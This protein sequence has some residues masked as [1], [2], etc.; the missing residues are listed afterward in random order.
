M[1]QFLAG[2]ISRRWMTLLCITTAMGSVALAQEFPLATRDTWE[3][4]GWSYGIE[5]R[6]VNERSVAE[7]FAEEFVAALVNKDKEEFWSLIDSSLMEE[8]SLKLCETSN[9]RLNIRNSVRQS[10][11]GFSIQIAKQGDD[12]TFVRLLRT[13]LGVGPIF[14]LKLSNGGVTYHHWYL[15]QNN[16]GR[17]KGV[18]VYIFNAGES[19]AESMRRGALLVS[20]S[21]SKPFVNLLSKRDKDLL[22]HRDAL[23]RVIAAHKL[24]DEVQIMQAYNALP[25]ELK[26]IKFCM[27]HKLSASAK[28]SS[29]RFAETLAEFNKVYA[30]DV[31][32]DLIAMDY[33]EGKG[34]VDNLIKTVSRIQRVIHPDAHLFMVKAK[35]C[36]DR[37]DP[38]LCRKLLNV[39]HKIE[40]D[41][42]DLYWMR[43]ACESAAGN[44][45]TTLR[46]FKYLVKK[47]EVLDFEY[48][49]ESPHF[50]GFVG[51]SQHDVFQSYLKSVK[52]LKTD[53]LTSDLE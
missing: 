4:E 49:G 32:G 19:L 22:T 33:Y 51:T 18:D 31:A 37:G 26:S 11:L 45:D 40:P 41:F 29:E 30:G 35:A 36:L 46:I 14:R 3:A 24:Q 47:Y 10:V 15:L 1:R 27:L 39:A 44:Y 12:Y 34:Q 23:A 13:K 2:M 50:K 20:E 52:E 8:R 42:Q 28:Y 48:L 5:W 53:Y 38:A 16:E 21:K 6:P 43:A 7:D 17:I 25:D 9:A